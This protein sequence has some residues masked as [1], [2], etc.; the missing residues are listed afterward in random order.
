M[1]GNRERRAETPDGR[2]RAP[3]VRRLARAHPPPTAAHNASAEY[4]GSSVVKRSKFTLRA[5]LVEEAFERVERRG[6]VA[7]VARGV[8]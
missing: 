6:R 2:T 8:V 5:A 1:F 7:C 3:P 4:S